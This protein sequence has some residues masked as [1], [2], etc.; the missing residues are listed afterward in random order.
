[1][2]LVSA[3]VYSSWPLGYLLNPA[4]SH[5]SLASGLEAIG[6]PY[7]KLFIAGDVISSLLILIVIWLLWHRLDKIKDRRWLHGV[8]IPVLIFSVGTIADALLPERCVPGLQTCPNFTQ[9][10]LLLWHGIF[11]ILAS[12]GLFVSLCLLWW[13][14]KANHLLTALLAGYVLFG[15]V[16]LAEAVLPGNPGNWSQHYYITLCSIWLAVLPLS[17]RQVFICL[18][19]LNPAAMNLANQPL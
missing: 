10:H 11:S 2:A 3:I 14:Q 18:S 13:H 7:N 16:S 15:I 19:S 9:D 8:V 6:Q 12:L 4:V 5:S 1:M 17:V